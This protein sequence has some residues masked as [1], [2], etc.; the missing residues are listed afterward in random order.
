MYWIITLRFSCS[1]LINDISL[2]VFFLRRMYQHPFKTS[3]YSG[4]N[5]THVGRM[6][7]NTKPPII[8]QMNTNYTIRSTATSLSGGS[9]K[10]DSCV[11]QLEA[12]PPQQAA[13]FTIYCHIFKKAS[14]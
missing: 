3:H 13:L 14:L 7:S 5:I 2:S 1:H 12:T 9:L 8:H 10:P 11:A 4:G 6:D